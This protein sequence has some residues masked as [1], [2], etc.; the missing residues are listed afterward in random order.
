MKQK[1][2]HL[3]FFILI[4]LLPKMGTAQ[5]AQIKVL[6]I[7][8]S[9]IYNNN[10][11]DIE[12]DLVK[13]AGI[14][15]QI[16]AYLDTGKSIDYFITDTSCFNMIKSASW[17]YIVI[18]DYQAYYYDSLGKFD[19]M[20]YNIPLLKNNLKFQDSIKKLNPC[21]KIIYFAGWEQFGGVPDRFPGDNTEKMIKRI[22][23]NYKFLNDLPSVHNVIAP[24]GVA[25]IKCLA[26]NPG[27]DFYLYGSDNRHPAYGGSYLSA[28][29][30]FSTIF[31]QSP[32]NL[33]N[34]FYFIPPKF[35]TIFKKCAIQAVMD[36][37]VFT[38]LPEITPVVNSDWKA[39]YTTPLY[40]SYQ[41]YADNSLISGATDYKYYFM[42]YSKTY[43][44]ITTDAKG[45]SLKS[46][47][48][49]PHDPVGVPLENYRFY[50]I[51]TLYQNSPNPFSEKTTINYTLPY[52]SV[53]ASLEITNLTG[54]KRLKKINL[55]DPG[56]G[57]A[58][59]DMTEF[60][61]GTY[62]Y[63]LII[64]NQKIDTKKMIYIR[65]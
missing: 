29:V 27:I 4:G 21:V 30:L 65:P 31:R 16:S 42:D 3:L 41:W 11:P 53:S 9:F 51:P 35:D 54:N 40:T 36:S 14:H 13:A 37:L 5:S 10:L 15:A 1:L 43:S 2:N 63:C 52:N 33:K 23:A 19:S 34:P 8:N 44:V 61:S 25:W 48:I 18:Q 38:S 58:V 60:E 6:M 17:D 24:I 62:T 50:Q 47:Q 20:G 55:I 59:V 45:C 57:K 64:N 26:E 32:V 22:L 56:S 49:K 28:C 39:V 12:R 7:G 46:F